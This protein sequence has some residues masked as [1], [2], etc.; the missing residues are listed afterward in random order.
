[1][2]EHVEVMVVPVVNVD[3][4]VYTHTTDRF[5]RKNRRPGTSCVG[6]DLNRNWAMDYNGGY[7][8]S[9]DPCNNEFIGTGA[10]SEPETSALRDIIETASGIIAHLDLH[11]CGG[12]VFGPWRF[13]NVEPP[14]VQLVDRVGKQFTHDISKRFGSKYTFVRGGKGVNP[15]RA[16]GFMSDWTFSKGIMS[17]TVEMRPLHNDLDF[18]APKSTI[19]PQCFAPTEELILPSCI[20]LFDGME[21]L[22]R[23]VNASSGPLH[24][25]LHDRFHKIVARPP[26][27]TNFVP[28]P[29]NFMRTYSSSVPNIATSLLT[30]LKVVLVMAIL[31]ACYIAYFAHIKRAP[32]VSHETRRP[33]SAKRTLETVPLLSPDCN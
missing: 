5:W 3:G 23:F 28:L 21:N 16:S 8:A 25:S 4:F 19:N 32:Q 24:T 11:T 18:T 27:I 22:L 17:F 2:L 33:S 26:S 1:M 29:I 31:C 13:T 9:N 15:M 30:V 14:H 10:F 12:S 7:D 20:E 6:V